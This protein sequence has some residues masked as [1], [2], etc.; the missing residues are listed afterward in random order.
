LGQFYE[1]SPERLFRLGDVIT[2]FQSVVPQIDRPATPSGWTI[3]VERPDYMVVLTPCC[4]IE[5][6]SIALAPLG[7]IRPSFLSNE[8]FVQDLTNINRKMSPEKSVARAVWENKLPEDRK[9]KMMASGDCYAMIECFVYAPHDLLKTYTLN[10]KPGPREVAHY[11]VDFKSIFRVQCQ[12]IGRGVC[13]PRGTK[14]LQ[15]TKETRRE[16]R[17]KLSFYFGRLPEED[18]A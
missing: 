13:A 10:I 11:L 9:Q 5:D 4:S 17:E 15:L 3:T 16:L 12:Q 2:G 14:I 18:A 7:Q 6:Q 1:A 8:Y